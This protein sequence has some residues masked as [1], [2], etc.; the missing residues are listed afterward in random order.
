MENKIF[1]VLRRDR[2]LNNMQA[3]YGV[4]LLFKYESSRSLMMCS[5]IFW[6]KSRML[7]ALFPKEEH[8]FGT[9][10]IRAISNLKNMLA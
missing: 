9:G 3:T 5:V 1:E 7:I 8:Y 4:L 6:R 2:K 10:L